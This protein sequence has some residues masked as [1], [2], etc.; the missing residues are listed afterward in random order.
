MFDKIQ[1]Q[2]YA[3]TGGQNKALSEGQRKTCFL[4]ASYILS[5]REIPHNIPEGAALYTRRPFF[6]Y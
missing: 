2:T 5:L 3:P 6:S 4:F 1:V